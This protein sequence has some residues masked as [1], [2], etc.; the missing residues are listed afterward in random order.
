MTANANKAIKMLDAIDERNLATDDMMSH[1]E[2][3]FW[4]LQRAFNHVM[5]RIKEIANAER[6]AKLAK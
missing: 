5:H 4:K 3:G 2:N 1:K 6:A